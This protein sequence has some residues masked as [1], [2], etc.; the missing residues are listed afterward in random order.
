MLAIA[1]VALGG[2]SLIGGRGS[3]RGGLFGAASIFLLQDV[4]TALDVPS[5]WLRSAYG[6]ALLAGVIVG[7]RALIRPRRENEAA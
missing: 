7:A 6:A 3:L 4:L 2:T 1:A 5:T